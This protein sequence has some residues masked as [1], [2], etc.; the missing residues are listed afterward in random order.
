MPLTT[1]VINL[2]KKKKKCW[3]RVSLHILLPLPASDLFKIR[4]C[5]SVKDRQKTCFIFG[6]NWLS[7]F[8]SEAR[9]ASI[10]P[11]IEIGKRGEQNILYR[12]CYFF[13]PQIR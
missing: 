9:G 7:G 4:T 5:D 13:A 8:H 3:L 2:K 12:P 10:N 6:S 11:D 1:G